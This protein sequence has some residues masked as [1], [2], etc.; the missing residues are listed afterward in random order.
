MLTRVGLVA[1][2]SERLPHELSGGQAQRVAIARALI[3][4]PRVLICDEAL[5][6]LDG[7]VRRDIMALLKAEQERSQMSLI[8]I[9]H[10]LGVVREICDRVIVMHDGAVCEEG[11][12]DD[13]F[14]RAQHPYTQALL[15]AVPTLD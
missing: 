5:S 3:L 15:A 13:I 14:S 8:F 11:S 1:A 6:A 10:D 7:T 2:L 12:N 9:T 4:E